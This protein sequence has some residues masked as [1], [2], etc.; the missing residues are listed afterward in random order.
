MTRAISGAAKNQDLK[1]NELFDV[2]NYTA[3]V[4]GGGSGIG[5]MITRPWFL[6]GP[7]LTYLGVVRRLY[8]LS[9]KSTA[10]LL[11][12]LLRTFV[13]DQGFRFYQKRDLAEYQRRLQASRRYHKQGRD[14][15]PRQ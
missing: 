15:T 4:T 8:R 7:R 9:L 1:V 12:R 3:V 2:S 5:L 14:Q 10:L 13:L 11:A 6:M